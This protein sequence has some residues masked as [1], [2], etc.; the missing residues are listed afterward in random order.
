[1]VRVAE[2]E[3]VIKE[4]GGYGVKMQGGRTTGRELEVVHYVDAGFL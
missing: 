1:M 4:I 2:R 3:E